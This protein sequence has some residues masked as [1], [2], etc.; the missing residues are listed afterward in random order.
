MKKK[1]YGLLLAAVIAAGNPEYYPKSVSV[2]HIIFGY[3]M[4]S[5]LSVHPL[6]TYFSALRSPPSLHRSVLYLHVLWSKTDS[7]SYGRSW[8]D[9]CCRISDTH[10]SAAPRVRSH[11]SRTVRDLPPHRSPYPWRG[12]LRI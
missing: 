12:G 7:R 8:S 5:H 1:F 3:I 6:S 4:I 2:Q 9:S 11:H 10:P